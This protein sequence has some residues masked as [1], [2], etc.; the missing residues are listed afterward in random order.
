MSNLCKKK[1]KK[2]KKNG[3]VIVQEVKKFLSQEFSTQ[4]HLH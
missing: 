4:K 1:K 3:I 2:I